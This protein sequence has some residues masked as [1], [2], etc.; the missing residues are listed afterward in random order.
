MV[1]R[2]PLPDVEIPDVSLYDFLLGS[3]RD[4]E[5]DRV[6][7]VDGPTGAATTYGALRA[8]VDALAG[9]LAARGVGPGT[10]VGLHSPNV[11]AFA[12]AFHAILRAGATATTV[13]ALAT[14]DDVA[15]QLAASGAALLL[16]VSPLLPA[17][18]KGAEVAGLPH[19]RV[20]VLDGAPGHES[21]RDLL[22]E[23]RPAPQ[24]QVLASD[25][26]VLPYSS[27]TAGRPK[28]VMLT[29]RNLVANVL[30]ASP[31]AGVRADDTVLALLPFFH[32]YGM[33]VLLD[34][35]LHHRAQL[36]TMPRFDLTE[37]CR[38]VAEHRITYAPIAP[39][40]AVALAK[41]PLIDSF[42]F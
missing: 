42:D 29:H 35:A 31:Y 8:Q 25:L 6:A 28:G 5:L 23:Q 33:T 40:V 16:T 41:H 3:L 2:S 4:D 20:I 26:A 11:P 1:F 15:A 27:G 7:I 39:P 34:L 21:L 14:A 19:S 37:F 24:V 22:T 10:V 18:V 38:I 12:V 17:A 13:N 9:A 32:I 36:V 30:Q